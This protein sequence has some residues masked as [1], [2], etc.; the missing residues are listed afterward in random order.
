MAAYIGKAEVLVEVRGCVRFYRDEIP[1]KKLI[2]H[3]TRPRSHSN[4]ILSLRCSGMLATARLIK[5]TGPGAEARLLLHRPASSHSS[6]DLEPPDNMSAI[7]T[8][9]LDEAAHVS[10]INPPDDLASIQ[11]PIAAAVPSSSVD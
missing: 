7:N 2:R 1:T 3:Y 10:P 11:L 4:C 6:V 8:I 5:A 9:S